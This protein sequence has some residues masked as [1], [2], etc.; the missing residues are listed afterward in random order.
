MPHVLEAILRQF[1]H[2]LY[3][4]SIKRALALHLRGEVRR[5]G[6]NPISVT[7]RLEIEW[8]ARDIHPWDRDLLPA[9]EKAAA[10]VDQ[11]LHDTEAAICRLFTALPPLHVIALKV[12]DRAS[13]DVILSGSVS[14][15]DF[16]AREERLSVGMRLMYMGVTHHSE[17][18]LFEPLENDHRSR[19]MAQPCGVPL[20]PTRECPGAVVY[21]GDASSCGDRTH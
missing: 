1:G 8:R 16:A 7:T 5:D 2:Y 19:P 9:P 20:M 11:A 6:L 10:F 18:S 13:Q 14:R 15:P 21:R 12:L 4:R 17:G 3:K